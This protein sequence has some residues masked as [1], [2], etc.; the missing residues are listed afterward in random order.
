[1]NVALIREF[2]RTRRK[3][4]A[5]VVG[6]VLLNAGLYSYLTMYQQPRLA[7]LQERVFAAR[8][9]AGRGVP[10]DADTVYRQ[11]AADLAEW[12]KRI[13]AKKE[14][15]R[16]LGDLYETAR[17]NSLG[18]GGVSY[19]PA[20]LKGEVMLTYSITFNVSGKYAQVKS[21]IA[22][23]SRMRDIVVIDNISLNNSKM[24]EEYVDL[25]LE[26]TAYFRMEG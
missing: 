16:L 7:S 1:M 6:L 20:A 17:T 26:L 10:Q 14:F 8:A 11:G 24:T 4:L 25:R 22:D 23:V 19:K 13:P 12:G 15:A 18:V 9:S 21:F 5:I 2:I 3:M